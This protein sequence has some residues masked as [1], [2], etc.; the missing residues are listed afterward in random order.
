MNAVRTV[1]G[2]GSVGEESG[3]G[4]RQPVVVGR[5]CQKVIEMVGDKH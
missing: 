2:K 4:G 3:S 5:E 1:V